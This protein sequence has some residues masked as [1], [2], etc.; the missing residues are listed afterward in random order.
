LPILFQNW[1][2]LSLF[3]QLWC[4]LP[5][6]AQAAAVHLKL[7]GASAN[8]ASVDHDMRTC[9][10]AALDVDPTSSSWSA[11][12]AQEETTRELYLVATRHR[13]QRRRNAC[14]PQ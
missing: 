11:A 1:Q 8:M 13:A 5:L 7:H 9:Y 2:T 6:N 10:Q 4:S 12:T 3:H 14:G